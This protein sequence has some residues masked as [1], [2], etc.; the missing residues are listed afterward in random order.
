MRVHTRTREKCR[1]LPVRPR[2]E[3]PSRNWQ[4]DVGKCASAKIRPYGR[5]KML[6]CRTGDQAV[7]M[8]RRGYEGT[9]TSMAG[10]EWSD[11]APRMIQLAFRTATVSFSDMTN[12]QME[13]SWEVRSLWDSVPGLPGFSDSQRTKPQRAWPGLAWLERFVWRKDRFD[14]ICRS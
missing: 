13:I 2:R 4:S 12:G 11:L 1:S 14:A 5:A 3:A 8:Q 6:R 9:C 10:G 7:E